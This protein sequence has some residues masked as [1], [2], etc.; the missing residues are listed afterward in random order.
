VV[1]V[2][3]ENNPPEFEY[4]SFDDEEDLA[5]VQN[6]FEGPTPESDDEAN[7]WIWKS[8]DPK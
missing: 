8:A 2:L 6:N 3:V 1:E 4:I 7:A 5:E